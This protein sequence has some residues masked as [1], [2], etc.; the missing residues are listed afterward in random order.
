[1]ADML[2]IA[3]IA[4]TAAAA[5]VPQE[6]ACCRLRTAE[7]AR[8]VHAGALAAPNA[9]APPAA[10]RTALPGAEAQTT[11]TL[12]RMIRY[13]VVGGAVGW[14]GGALALGGPLAKANP[15]ESDQLDDG[16]WTPGIVIGFEVGQAIGIPLAVHLANGRQGNLRASLAA[17]TALAALGTLLIWT[18]DFDAV[19]ESPG[20][21]AVLIGIPIAQFVAA[22]H[23]ERRGTR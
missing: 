10:L 1:M 2:A 4:L 12:E 6:A 22:V 7:P 19:L 5:D 9:I 8:A 21:Q 18:D 3:A 15:F 16:L 11:A 13:G 20:R 14:V 23:F 17:S